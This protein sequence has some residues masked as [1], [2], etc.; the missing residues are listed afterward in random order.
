MVVDISE[1][2]ENGDINVL[3]VA[4]RLQKA[5]D[6]QKV[7]RQFYTEFADLKVEFIDLIEGIAN[8]HDRH[9]YASVILNRLMFIYFLQRKGFVNN[10]DLEYLQNKL[11]ESQARG[12]DRYYSE[13]L[14][15][16]FFEG[17]A[18][19]EEKRS[20]AA[21][22]M[23]GKIRYLN[24]GLFLPHSIEMKYA[25]SAGSGQALTPGPS[26]V[27]GGERSLLPTGEGLGMR[28]SSG[29]SIP[30]R[31]FERVLG[32]FARYSWNLDDTPGGEDNEINPDV[33]GYIFEKYINQKAFGAYYTRAE[34]T[35]HLCEQAIYR[36]ILQKVN[37]PGLAGVLAERRFENI[38][39]LL[40]HLDAPLCRQLL[41]DIL[42]R[43]SILDPACGSG[44][45]LVAAMR[46]LINVYSAIIG[47]IAFLNDKPLND[48]LK[49]TQSEHPNIAYFIKRS[50]IT[51]NLFGV[52]IME[53]ATEIARLRLF[54]ALVASV[55]TVE[56]LEPLPNIDFNILPG[57][58]LVGMLRV[59]EAAFNRKMAGGGQLSLF[60][61]K[62]YK[63]I[64]AE[65]RAALD[66]YRHASS[67][68]EDLGALRE[69]IQQR[70]CDDYALLNE[71]LVDEFARL[72]I[73]V[74]P[75]EWDEKK[76][77]ERKGRKRAVQMADIAALQPFH[78]GYEFD[79]VM[80]E[81][82]GFD[83]IVTNPPWEVLQTYE[84]EFFQQYA[85]TIQ[86]KNL[87]IE[88]WEKQKKDLMNDKELQSA[89]L[90][91]SSEFPH[92]WAY[93]KKSKQYANQTTR[94]EGRAS[95]NKPN[96]YYLFIEQSVNLLR[97]NGSC[98]IVIP[99]GI[100]TDFSTMQLREMLFTENTV[101]GI[102]GFEN[103]KIIFEG[104]DSRFKFVVLTFERGGSTSVFPATFMKHDVNELQQFPQYNAVNISVDLIRKL[105]PDSLSIP[106]FKV[107][108]DV[109]IA[110]KV[111]QYPMLYGSRD[112]WELELYGEE[113]NMTRSAEFFKTN[114]SPYQ[115]YEGNMI[116]Q[117]DHHYA[118]PRYWLNE[119]EL[120][121][122]FLEK[123]IKRAG[124]SLV[125][126][127]MKNDYE[128]FRIAIRKI[129][130]NTNERTLIAAI[131]P[132]NSF[133][134]HSLSVN[135][136]FYHDSEK[137]NQL[138][139]S[140]S[141]LIVIAAFINSFVLDYVLRARMTTN[142]SLFYLYQLPVPR[143]DA[144]DPAFAPIVERAAKLICVTPEFDDLLK[145]LS[146][147]EY[148]KGLTG[149]TDPAARAQLRAELDAMIAHLYG[150]T[151]SELAHILS[152]FPLVGEDVKAGVMREFKNGNS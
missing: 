141:E 131:I 24:G 21:R 7:T 9:W 146:G 78:W 150:L 113:L 121:K 133:A 86:R 56:E 64:V 123:R 15:T 59:D 100:Y 68:T 30:D 152:T 12:P 13:F 20:P 91:Y 83:V 42:P 46:T 22:Q 120:R 112:G 45:F 94:V 53:E 143:L 142:L 31:A 74:E 149:V 82:G 139:H 88:D 35:A 135:F 98:G 125:P 76:K 65:K 32:L 73:K 69:T 51:D 103:R 122:V 99:S 148:L 29:I 1:L 75:V 137:Y 136:P 124:L 92:Q 6:V 39:E 106:E 57:N 132:P 97:L 33:L 58:S 44:A 66:A 105:S 108:E 71:L 127:D 23:L 114:P 34:I 116:W 72:E 145:D 50:I 49:K 101:T 16:L 17:F 81:R 52:D 62:S 37:T 96:L 11:R 129:A 140:Y 89:W 77:E 47:R 130:S 26:P 36:V 60:Q 85:D 27:G 95:G 54:L 61:Q 87:R 119:Q 14:T 40:T 25:P 90:A 10:R 79:E 144:G 134:G 48:W 84:K 117:F 3:A 2:D 67:F 138:R 115:L 128:V 28:A 8:D 70:R 107:E 63:Q 109:E 43:L 102:F 151:E 104:V 4:G 38:A 55:R 41:H 118:S 18:K 93:F 111:L 147:F 110:N 80:N 126:K 19:P 5:L